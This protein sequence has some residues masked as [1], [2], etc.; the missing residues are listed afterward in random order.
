MADTKLIQ[1][2]M[3]LR[4]LIEE[5]QKFVKLPFFVHLMLK[6]A[7]FV[8]RSDQDIRPKSFIIETINKFQDVLRVEHSHVFCLLFYGIKIQLIDHD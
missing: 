3:R 4:H 8:V 7:Q 2:E 1:I 5:Q 6:T